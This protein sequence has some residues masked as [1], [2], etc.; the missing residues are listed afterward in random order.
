MN[1]LIT[2]ANGF[3]GKHLSRVLAAGNT[4]YGLMHDMYTSNDVYPLR[5]DVT[6]YWRM[7][8]IITDREIDQI[9]HLA[10]KSI[11]RNCIADPLECFRTNAL[12]TAT[13]LEAARQY[14]RVKGILLMESDKAYGDGPVPYDETQQLRPKAVYEAS[15]ACVT[16]IMSAYWHNYGVPVFSVRS[17]N[18]YGPGDWNLSRIIPNTITRILHGQKP[19]LTAGAADYVR[20]FLYVD[21]AVEC[22]TR[23]MAVEPWG[24]VVNVGSGHY[25]T[26]GEVIRSICR[27]MGVQC[28]NETWLKPRD[29][30]EIM[31]QYMCLDKFKQYVTTFHP[32]DFDSGLRQTIEWYKRQEQ[33]KCA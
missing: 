29:L 14:G 9:Y 5:G 10:A 21:D 19:Q 11:V 32:T 1:I 17:A 6:D 30:K 4:V 27:I 33:I 7:L 8:E 31:A 20:E 3:V 13:V 22:M 16:H 2:G 28:E 12:G 15:K 25:A 18:I 26:I 23:L 24:E